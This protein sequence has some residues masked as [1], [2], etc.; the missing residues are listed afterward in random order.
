MSQ[1]AEAFLRKYGGTEF[2]VYSAGLQPREID[3]LTIKVMEEVG[4]NLANHNSEPLR[5]YWGK[6]LYDCLVI[7]C[8]KA[9][10]ECF[11]F[12]GVTDRVFWAFEDP[13]T[14]EMPLETR[15]QAF[16]R[17]RDRI[18]QRIQEWLKD[19]KALLPMDRTREEMGSVD[20]PLS[21]SRYYH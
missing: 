1:M 15:I 7:M 8:K 3:P 18:E 21:A 6:M 5:K 20:E 17:T 2:E 13:G 12:P 19:G 4:V 9:D 11:L 14:H 16:R 10:E